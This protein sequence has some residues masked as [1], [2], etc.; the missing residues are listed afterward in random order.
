MA[1]PIVAPTRR[2]DNRNPIQAMRQTDRIDSAIPDCR[3]GRFSDSQAPGARRIV[4]AAVGA[5]MESSKALSAQ[6]AGSYTVR[7]KRTQVSVMRDRD[8]RKGRS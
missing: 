5:L 4:P 6:V 3:Y 2:Q 7:Q 1:K 8:R